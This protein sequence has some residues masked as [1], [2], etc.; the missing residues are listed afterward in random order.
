M[1]GRNRLPYEE[2]VKLDLYNVSHWS[3][4]PD[5]YILALTARAVL[6]GEVW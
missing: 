2:R 5:L 6:Q 1:S 4:W 3:V